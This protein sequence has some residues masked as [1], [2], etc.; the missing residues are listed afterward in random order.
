MIQLSDDGECPLNPLDTIGDSDSVLE[1]N[2]SNKRTVN[3]SENS[4]DG[5]MV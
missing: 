4:N 3:E 1:V 5:E 2:Y